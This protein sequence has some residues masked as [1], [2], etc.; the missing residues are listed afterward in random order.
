M[1]HKILLNGQE[2]E[3][4]CTKSGLLLYFKEISDNFLTN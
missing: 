2:K 3:E 1:Q 4:N